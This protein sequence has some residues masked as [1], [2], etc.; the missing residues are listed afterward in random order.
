[1]KIERFGKITL[2][3]GDC[4]EYLR[5]CRDKQFTLGCVDPPYAD[6]NFQNPPQQRAAIVGGVCSGSTEDAQCGIT[7]RVMSRTGGTW[8]AK[9]N[10]SP[11]TCGTC[12]DDSE[13]SGGSQSPRPTDSLGQQSATGIWWDIAPSKEYFDELFRVTDNQIIWGGNY[14][15][16]PPTRCFLVWRKLS[17][18]EKFTMAMCEYAWTSFFSNAKW[19]ECAPQGTAKC[20]RFHPTQKPVALYA[21]IYN[22]YCKEG[23]TI[24]DTH[25]GSGSSAIAAYELGYEFVGIEIDEIYYEKAKERLLKRMAQKSLFEDI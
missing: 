12:A 25:L 16:L 7:D 10:R 18:S 14:F 9:Y 11:T 4:M 8:A 17:I 23:D 5:Q 24:L 3:H 21:W 22:N 13:N 15:D 20:P 6:A 1:M 2:I 19:F